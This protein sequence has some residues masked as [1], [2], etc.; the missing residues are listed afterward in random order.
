MT[1]LALQ[2]ELAK[3]IKGLLKGELYENPSGDMVPINVYTQ[4]IPVSESKDEDEP[5]PY[6]I[7]RLD[8]G[9]DLGGV[10]RSGRSYDEGYKID[11]I[12]IITL[13]KETKE[14][15]GYRSLVNIINRIYERY[16][17]RPALDNMEGVFDGRFQWKL[18]EDAYYPY[19][20][21][22]CYLTFQI[23]AVQKED[24]LI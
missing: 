12:I 9:E 23:P 22:A 8:S 4:L 15:Q 16:A 18:Q 14:N 6:I 3:E 24:P 10:K 13:W 19:C 21:G 20:I 5:V 11:V 7:V 17:K 1:P 2:D